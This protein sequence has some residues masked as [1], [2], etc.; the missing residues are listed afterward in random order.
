MVTRSPRRP[1]A[2]ALLATSFLCAVASGAH[3]ASVEVR[4]EDRSGQPLEHAVISLHDGVARRA[5]A[6]TRATIDQRARQ[7][8]PT[9]VPIQAGTDVAF[10]NSDDV[11]HHV[12]SFSHPNAF[13]LKLYHGEPSRPVRFDE[14]GIV[15]LG[16]NI[17]DGMLGYLHVVDTPLFAKSAVSGTARIDGAAEG[18][19]TL[20]VWHPDLGTRYLR[21]P[22]ALAGALT[23]FVVTLDPADADGASLAAASPSPA[24]SAPAT[25]DAAL[26]EEL[27]SLFD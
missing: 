11:R 18:D 5:P 25:G 22:V 1:A 14:P 13:E 16:C 26:I 10:P 23:R 4:I 15:V 9:V 7:F 24:R 27:G 12:Y 6:G 19:Y 3:A 21:R 17:H 20:Q 8:A 2:L